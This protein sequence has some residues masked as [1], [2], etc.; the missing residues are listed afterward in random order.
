MY[1]ID[2]SQQYNL[3]T[4]LTV[5]SE[6]LVGQCARVDVVRMLGTDNHI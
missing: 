1:N 2:V 4:V 6:A 5:L 3:D